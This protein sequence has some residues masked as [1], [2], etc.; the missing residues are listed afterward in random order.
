[1]AVA[2]RAAF[3][4][5]AASAA[6]VI[7]GLLCLLLSQLGNTRGLGPIGALGIAGALVASLTFLPAVLLLFGRRIFWP[8]IPRVDHVHAEDSV[9]VS[10]THL[11]LPTIYSV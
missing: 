9:A 3:S 4:P 6:T 8:I 2:W 7:L 11:T 10:Y 1:M 5:V